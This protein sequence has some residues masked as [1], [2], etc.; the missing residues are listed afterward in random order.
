MTATIAW[1]YDAQ[2]L[3]VISFVL[4]EV[5]GGGATGTVTLSGQY[6]HGV[7]VNAGSVRRLDVA[8]GEDVFDFAESY[9]ELGGALKTAME[10]VGNATYTVVWSP[11][12]R[13]YNVLAS[14]VTS[15]SISSPSVGATRMLGALAVQSALYWASSEEVWHWT[16]AENL[17]FSRWDM[18]DASPDGAEALVG[19]DGSVRGLSAI[20]TPKLLDFVVPSEPREAIR[21]DESQGSYAPR[22]WT[23]QRAVIRCRSVEPAVISPG[24]NLQ[25]YVGF[26]RPDYTFAPRLKSADYLEVQDVPYSFYIVGELV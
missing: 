16:Y 13:A 25:A 5:G 9:L 23:H 14:G 26:L 10:D 24:D 1:G 2:N 19:S 7:T 6:M 15:F 22:G 20:G 12:A 3:G 8:T 4:T 11:T 21:S 17:G 18:R